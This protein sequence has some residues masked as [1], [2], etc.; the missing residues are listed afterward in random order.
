MNF[1]RFRICV[2]CGILLVLANDE[3]FERAGYFPRCFLAAKIVLAVLTNYQSVI[4]YNT[5]LITPR[6]S[7]GDSPSVSNISFSA[8]DESGLSASLSVGGGRPSTKNN[9]CG[10]W[11][12]VHTI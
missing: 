4:P 10:L 3:S 7:D 8:S 1:L 11:E 2:F 6:T 12:L 9:D 5:T